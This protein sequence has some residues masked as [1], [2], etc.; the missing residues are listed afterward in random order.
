MLLMLLQLCI[1]AGD[2]S[3]APGV[4]DML[5][6]QGR[7]KYLRPLYRALFRSPTGKQLALDTFSKEGGRYHPIA[8]KMVEV[9]LQL[10]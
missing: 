9:D 4:V 3:I 10:R 5:S 6:S 8:K 7:M 2:S 1:A